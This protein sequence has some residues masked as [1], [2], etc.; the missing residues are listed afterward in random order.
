[1]SFYPQ[2]PYGS[3]QDLQGFGMPDAGI[4]GYAP[5][6]QG[7]FPED[8]ND[9]AIGEEAGS[10][11]PADGG[12]FYE[13]LA[14][15]LEE[16]ELNLLA[17][18]LIEDIQDD[19]SS[20]SEWENSCSTILK[21]L[22]WKLEEYKKNLCNAIDNT[23]STTLM[24]FLALAKSELFPA[25]GPAKGMVEGY[26]TE[27]L[28][29]RAERVQLFINYF[30][31]VVDKAYYPDK[32][33]LL[34]YVGLFGSAFTK[35][36]MDP[37]TKRPSLRL[38]K[39]Q[40]L[41]INNSCTSILESDRI[42]EQQ[43]LSLKYILI[44]ERDGVFIKGTIKNSDDDSSNGVSSV[45]K[46]IKQME[47]VNDA[48]VDSENK[49]LFKFYESHVDLDPERVKDGI[50][51]SEED[52]E[53]NIPRPYIV[54]I[55]VNTGKIA[56]IN[57]NWKPKDENFKRAECFVH[58]YYL[59]G[60]GIYSIGL[61]HLQGSN[62]IVLTNILRQCLDAESFKIF[63]AGFIQKGAYPES[64][65]I[66]LLPGEFKELQTN[67]QPMANVFS[68]LPYNGASPIM[69]QLRNELKGDTSTLGGASQQVAPIGASDAPVGTTL[70]QI[71]VRDRIP[72]NVLK[73]IRNS[74][75]YELQLLRDLFAEY[76]PEGPYPFNVPGNSAQVMREDFGDT[77]NVVPVA[78]PNLITNSQRIII[79][80]I[81]IRIAKENPT[82]FDVREA[83][84]RFLKSMKVED[85]DTIMPKPQDIM[86]ADPITEN[87]SLVMGKGAKAAIQQDH[88]AHRIVHAPIIQALSQDPAKQAELA[89]A[90]AHDAEHQAMEYLVQI[91][92]A[93]GQQMPD[94]QAL[95][96]PQIQNQI[97]MMAAQAVQQL[98]QQQQA[99]NPPPPN[100]AEVMLKDIQ[101]REEAARLKHEE[102][103]QKVEL[104]AF[105]AQ[106]QFESSKAKMDVEKELARDKNEVNLAIAK[107][108]QPKNSE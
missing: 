17:A 96:D 55:C 97:A 89:A 31:T 94:P 32:E 35:V 65:N 102:A 29:E 87:M 1:M 76:L 26:P 36:V 48:N 77:I 22:G 66:S 68:T 69:V 38:V 56:S 108:K 81:L 24:N 45:N 2:D 71:E 58:Y 79:N 60:F 62:A 4:N 6:P 75:S 59:P 64:N 3:P 10:Q 54:K 40:N 80:E 72:S 12:D 19:I 30:L 41:I 33:R 46:T 34:L 70:A 39:P 93:M 14:E 11:I 43:E 16:S 47:G 25:A 9:F 28:I 74:L 44:M 85:V 50:N 63:P 8:F 95:Q 57:R 86:P 49:S 53:E 99:Q 101:Q 92:Q 21:Y 73:S 78:D 13:N 5:D 67:E 18:E 52:E 51:F 7:E 105:K 37:F 103:Q 84:R 27:E 91:Q 82:L 20:R 106:T 15:N 100:P 98:Q 104:E 61:G 83:Y 88:S 90:K 107:M 42:T 23:L